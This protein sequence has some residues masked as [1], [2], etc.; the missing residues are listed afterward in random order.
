MESSWTH[1]GRCGVELVRVLRSGVWVQA[2][3]GGYVI[4]RGH[5]AQCR[6]CKEK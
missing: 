3:G 5:G 2:H 4:V 6:A 1:C